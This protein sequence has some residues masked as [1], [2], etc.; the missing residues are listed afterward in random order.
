MNRKPTDRAGWDPAAR[1]PPPARDRLARLRACP[2]RRGA[3]GRPAAGAWDPRLTAPAARAASRMWRTSFW[4]PHPPARTRTSAATRFG[5]PHR[6]GIS[7][8]GTR[9]SS[10]S[11]SSQARVPPIEAHVRLARRRGLCPA[12]TEP[13]RR[14]SSFRKPTPS[15]PRRPRRPRRRSEPTLDFARP[16]TR[17][18]RNCAE[19]LS[20]TSRTSLRDTRHVPLGGPAARWHFA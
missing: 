20:A 5:A 3:P 4:P 2:H 14:A 11:I 10:A 15:S 17:A 18:P 7:P 13:A 9:I 19:G 8:R 1:A 16:R 12:R 6:P